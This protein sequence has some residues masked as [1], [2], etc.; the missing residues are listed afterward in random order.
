MPAYVVHLALQ[1]QFMQLHVCP[2]GI[3]SVAAGLADDEAVHKQ[4]TTH[5][6]FHALYGHP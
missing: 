3:C 6:I 5:S 4:Q 2:Y 1:Q